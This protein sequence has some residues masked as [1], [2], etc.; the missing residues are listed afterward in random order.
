MKPSATS[1]RAASIVAATS[2]NERALVADHLELH[3]AVA[4][5]L[6]AELRRGDGVLHACSSRRCWAGSS[7]PSGRWAST[8]CSGGAFGSTRRS[9]TVTSSAP[10]ASTAA[11]C[12]ASEGYLPLPTISR[13]RNVCVAERVG[14]RHASASSDRL[15][16]LDPVARGERAALVDRPRHHARGSPRPPPAG[17]RGRAR[18]AAR[19][20]SSRRAPRGPRRSRDVDLRDLRADRG[21]ATCGESLEAGASPLG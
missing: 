18:G 15:E 2:G 21:G 5:E 4:E 14:V 10:L 17:R 16:D 13:E 3:E 9:A 11:R 19:R 8:F 1:T 7:T 6:A 12:T 20:R